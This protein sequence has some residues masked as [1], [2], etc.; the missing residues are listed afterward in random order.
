MILI[1]SHA[2]SP[3]LLFILKFIFNDILGIKFELTHDRDYFQNS[4]LPKLNY[5]DTPFKNE[6]FLFASRLLF[7]KGVADQ[8]ISV[9]DFEDSKA[10]FATHPKY[11]LPFDLFAAS[12]Y[13]VSRY[14]EYLPHKRD[15]HDRFEASQSLAYNKG[16]LQKPVI[17]CWAYSLKNILLEHYPSL[18]F[19]ERKYQ[20]LSTIDIDNAFAFKEK[21][22]FRTAGA[23][24][25]S[26]FALDFSD[27]KNRTAV[28]LGIKKDPYDTYELLNQIQASYHIQC[29]YFFLLGDYGD[30]DKNVPYTSHKLHTLIK[31]LADYAGTGIHPSYGSND[32]PDKIRNEVK[33]LRKI[34]KRDITNSR[35]HFLKLH[36]P[37]TYR[38]LID[39]D[40]TDDYT[41]GY[42]AEVGF[43]ASTC[44]PF[45]FYDLD[46]ET[47]TKLRIHPFAV[48]DAT[49]RYYMKVSPQEAIHTVKPLID[50][51]KKVN[52]TFVSLWHNESLSEVAP[53]AGW[54]KVYGQIIQTATAQ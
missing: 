49:L 9:F 3:R 5:S 54:S 26:L 15:M 45:H 34:L 35:Q 7:E 24:M 8:E 29:I 20:Y 43:R 11:L 53:W 2:T 52:G 10:F 37:V 12:F 38:N 6:P 27:I 4:K 47:E 33:R 17:D 22:M 46:L 18:Q 25:R 50:E 30:N 21:G 19:T 13:L 42:A 23:Y 28:L 32:D 14:E 36:F 40:I 31:S 44:T 39:N 16:F 1:F 51:V 48:M 41:M